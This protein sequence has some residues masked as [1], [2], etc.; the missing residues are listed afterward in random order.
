MPARKTMPDVERHRGKVD[1]LSTP[2]GCWLWTGP[3]ASRGYGQFSTGS[4]AQGTF[5][6]GGAHAF[7]LEKA[8]GRPLMPGMQALHTCD[9]KM[10]CRNEPPGFYEVNGIMRPCHGHL[11]EGTTQENTADRHAKGRDAAGER[12]GCSTR[13][14]QYPRGEAQWLAKLTEAQVRDI[15]RRAADG[16]FRSVLALEYGMG[17]SQISRIVRRQTWKHVA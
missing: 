7:A 17:R 8:L 11:W 12:N 5:K 15:R 1:R 14:E 13:P 9:V 6:N 2:D 16:E 4:R 10:C 3:P